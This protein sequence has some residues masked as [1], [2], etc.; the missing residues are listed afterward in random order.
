MR[1]EG[2]YSF[3]GNFYEVY[4]GETIYTI[5][6]N[7]P[8]NWGCISIGDTLP[9]GCKLTESMF[10]DGESKCNNFGVFVLR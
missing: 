4:A 7:A 2:K 1:V 6:V 5:P 3:D 9:N 8:L 10:R